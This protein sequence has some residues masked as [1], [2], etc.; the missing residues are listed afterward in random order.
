MSGKRL[1]IGIFG[2]GCVGSGLYETLREAKFNQAHI[3]RICVKDPNK[4]RTAPYALFTTD[5]DILLNDPEIDVIVELIDDAEAAYSIVKRALQSG[6]DV[7]SANKKL[8]AE[9]LDEL[10]SLQ[11]ET[12]QSFLYEAA[13]AASIPIIRNLEEYYDND[14]LAEVSGILN[15]STNFILSAIEEGGT[16]EAALELAQELGFAETDP[17]LD[18]DGWDAKYKTT[19][20]LAHGFGH[21]VS[22]E[23]V[24]HLGIQGISPEIQK[25]ANE[26]R[27]RIKLVGKCWRKDRKVHALVIPTFIEPGEDLASVEREV[28]GVTVVGAF[29]ERQFFRGK[30]AG[31]L[32]TA[33]AVLSDISAL[34]YGYRYEYKKLNRELESTYTSDFKIWAHV[35]GNDT[36]QLPT[37]AFDLISRVHRSPGHNYVEG[38]IGIQELISLA[39]DGHWSVAALSSSASVELEELKHLSVAL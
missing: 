27:Q 31:S 12:G 21:V 11:K 1:T 36:Q 22:P 7:V 10:I 28:N 4:S 38:K 5:A 23:N 9:H 34:T 14:L 29:S 6:K 16:F 3:K 18:V 37:Y 25:V 33:A 19:L 15:G 8:I 30:G 20:L 17:T 24:P 35:G 39:N 26:R 13:C 32:P 2:F